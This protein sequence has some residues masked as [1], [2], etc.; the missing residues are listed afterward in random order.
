MRKIGKWIAVISILGILFATE[1]FA[2]PAKGM[3][4]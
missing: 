4:Y 3:K 1:S 2:Q